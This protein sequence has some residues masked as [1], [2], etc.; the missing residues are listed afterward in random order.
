M[1]KLHLNFLVRCCILVQCEVLVYVLDKKQ[2]ILFFGIIDFFY[3]ITK[4]HLHVFCILCTDGFIYL[5]LFSCA[6][7]CMHESFSCL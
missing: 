7:R 5:Y 2:K 3:C 6:L 1:E 4:M